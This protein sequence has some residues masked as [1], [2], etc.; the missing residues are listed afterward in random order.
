[1]DRRRITDEQAQK[2]AEQATQS[3]IDLLRSQGVPEAEIQKLLEAKPLPE[4]RRK[5]RRAV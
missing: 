3:A 4:P 1:M 2:L 5:K